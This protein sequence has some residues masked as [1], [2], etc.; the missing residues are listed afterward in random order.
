MHC[1]LHDLSALAHLDFCYL[2]TGGRVLGKPHTIKSGLC[3]TT[4]TC[5]QATT[6]PIGG[7]THVI[8]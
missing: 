5:L 2:M 3:C 4:I 6:H 7:K 1:L 8:L